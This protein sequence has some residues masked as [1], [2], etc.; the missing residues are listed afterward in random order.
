ML[1]VYCSS[2]FGMYSSLFFCL[3]ECCFC[4]VLIL[5]CIFFTVISLSVL[6]VIFVVSSNLHYIFCCSWFFYPDSFYFAVPSN[7]YYT[8][9]CYRVIYPNFDIFLY[10]SFEVVVDIFNIAIGGKWE[11]N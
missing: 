9:Q 11:L 5:F 8:I 7:V 1:F 6:N 10:C 2:Y 4:V 3:S